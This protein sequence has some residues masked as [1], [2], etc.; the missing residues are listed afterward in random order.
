MV[1]GEEREVIVFTAELVEGDHPDNVELIELW[2]DV[3]TGMTVQERRTYDFVLDTPSA[4][5][6]TPKNTVVGDL[7]RADRLSD[8]SERGRSRMPRLGRV[9]SH[10][11]R[12]E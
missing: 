5:P 4:M 2:V 7:A 9:L 11:R 12:H 3:A 8:S 10:T 6:A 1:A